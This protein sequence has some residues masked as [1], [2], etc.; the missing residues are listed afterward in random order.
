MLTQDRRTPDRE[1][2]RTPDEKLQSFPPSPVRPW[3]TQIR[4]D[5]TQE[6]R[7]TLSGISP[8]TGTADK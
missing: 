3:Q 7:A 8:L 6:N 5:K 1:G 2:S 4:T